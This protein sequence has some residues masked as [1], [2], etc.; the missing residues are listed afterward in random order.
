M[1]VLLDLKDGQSV[2]VPTYD[3]TKHQR[4]QATRKVHQGRAGGLWGG[5]R[6]LHQRPGRRAAGCQAARARSPASCPRTK[7]CHHALTR[8]AMAA[9]TPPP[10]LLQRPSSACPPHAGGPG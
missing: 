2:E 5:S 7:R 6:A 1:K 9:C 4:A 3:F 10:P 8:C